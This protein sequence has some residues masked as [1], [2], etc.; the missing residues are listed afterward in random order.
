MREIF[1]CFFRNALI[2]SSRSSP[3]CILRLTIP[4][5]CLVPPLSL[6]RS[7]LMCAH[8]LLLPH[9]LPRSCFSCTRTRFPSHLSK[10][11]PPVHKRFALP[12]LYS[13]VTSTL[14]MYDVLLPPH[15]LSIVAPPFSLASKVAPPHCELL[16]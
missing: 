16:V 6:L 2:P 7:P 13:N 11:T 4:C 10:V 8:V 15:S 5:T 12:P 14:C 1:E 3:L 9:S